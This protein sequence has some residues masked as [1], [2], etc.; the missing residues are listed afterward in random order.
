MRDE[1]VDIYKD[2]LSSD[3]IDLMPGA[4]AIL[5]F[6]ARH[7]KSMY[8]VTNATKEQIAAIKPQHHVFKLFKAWITREDYSHP[9]PAP[10]GYL[11]AMEM[12]GNLS[13]KGIGFEDAIRGIQALQATSLTPVLI[14]PTN[15]PQP[16]P[17]DL[18]RVYLFTSFNELLE[19][20]L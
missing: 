8:V 12:H 16:N 5:E 9:K 19:K 2:L 6:L 3:P 11:K 15:Y 18:D 17:T 10:D 4:E 7:D 14:L 1:K 13:C 20:Q